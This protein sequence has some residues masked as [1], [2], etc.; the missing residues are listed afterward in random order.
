MNV[1]ERVI[2]SPRTYRQGVEPFAASAA[3]YLDALQALFDAWRVRPEQVD[4]EAGDASSAEVLPVL[5][6]GLANE[7]LDARQGAIGGPQASLGR[8]G[9]QAINIVR[10]FAQEL[11]LTGIEAL[12]LLQFGVNLFKKFAQ[13]CGFHDHSPFADV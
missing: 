6:L 12:N 11:L 5:D 1:R 10:E 8:L 9:Q 4:S 7:L 3:A 2:R 13:F